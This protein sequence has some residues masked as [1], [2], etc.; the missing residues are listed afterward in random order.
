MFVF[1]EIWL[2]LPS[3]NTHFEIHPFAFLPA[4]YCISRDRVVNHVKHI[5]RWILNID[6]NINIQKVY[7]KLIFII[8]IDIDLL[9]QIYIKKWN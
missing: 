8:F 6:Y 2:A 5:N 3:C 4:I 1:G 9:K 7:A